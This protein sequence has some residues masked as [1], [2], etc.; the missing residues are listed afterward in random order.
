MKILNS[1]FLFLLI[2][3]LFSLLAWQAQRHPQ[4][5]PMSALVERS[6]AEAAAHD[7]AQ[8]TA[9]FRLTAEDDM[10]PA[11]DWDRLLNRCERN[12]KCA[13]HFNHKGRNRS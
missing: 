8:A 2:L 4:T 10:D 9:P 3:M 12:P 7:R 13:N 1:P 5:D 11:G 6:L